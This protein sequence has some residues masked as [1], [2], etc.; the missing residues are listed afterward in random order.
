MRMKNSSAKRKV[1]KPKNTRNRNTPDPAT[2]LTPHESLTKLNM[3][4]ELKTPP[5]ELKGRQ[6]ERPPQNLQNQQ[7]RHAPV[8]RIAIWAPLLIVL[9]LALMLIVGVWRHVQQN[10]E[11][12]DFAQQ[13]NKT[14]V[15]VNSVK[16][17]S[18]PHD[19]WLPGNIV[20]EQETTIYARAD[21]Y[22]A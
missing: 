20:A 19:L 21:G 12:K 18:K 3:V 16:R 6:E 14:S 7:T 17:D 22:V 15:E 9:A 11:Q 2:A 10:R 1:K 13:I 4:A 5:K 8:S